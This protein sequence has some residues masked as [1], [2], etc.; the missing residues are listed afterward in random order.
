MKKFHIAAY[1]HVYG[2]TTVF[3]EDIEA[4]TEKDA[5]IEFERRHRL[6]WITHIFEIK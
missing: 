3:S 5:V 2:L 6:S 1:K 4:P